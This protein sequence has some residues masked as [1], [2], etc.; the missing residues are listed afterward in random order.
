MK[1]DECLHMNVR[2]HSWSTFLLSLSTSSMFPLLTES[3]RISRTTNP[4]TWNEAFPVRG[5]VGQE[6]RGGKNLSQQR[7]P[8]SVEEAILRVPLYLNDFGLRLRTTPPAAVS[9]R[10][11]CRGNLYPNSVRDLNGRVGCRGYKNRLI[12]VSSLSTRCRSLNVLR[13]TICVHLKPLQT[14]CYSFGVA[15]E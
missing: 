3:L 2:S 14:T 10:L 11:F 1:F 6:V 12:G 9:T 15:A 5:W 7:T 4:T 8:L 13:S